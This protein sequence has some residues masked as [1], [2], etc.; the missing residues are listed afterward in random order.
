[1]KTYAGTDLWSHVFLTSPLVGGGQ[2]H[3]PAVYPQGKSLYQPDTKLG[4]PQSLS[5]RYGEVKILYPT[6]IRTPTPR[7]SSP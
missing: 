2:V 1:M 4:G 6:G 7:L 5:G 3:A